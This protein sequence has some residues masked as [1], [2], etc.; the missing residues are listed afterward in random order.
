MNNFINVLTKKYAS[1]SGR[2]GQNEYWMFYL[3]YFIIYFA[4]M[5]LAFIL[6]PSIAA[7]I[8]IVA[9]V[10]LVGLLVPTI[11]IGVRRLHD[12]DHSGWFLLIGIIPLA[13][14][15]LLYLL[16][17]RGTEGDNRFGPSP[18]ALGD[19]FASGATVV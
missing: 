5:T 8:N 6:P 14:F 13:G 4:L 12:T 16:I 17:I 3:V 2:S 19:N 18:I 10:L 1:F 15:Y 7:A 11:A 9:V